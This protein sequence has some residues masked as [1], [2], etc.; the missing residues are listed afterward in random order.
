MQLLVGYD[1][2][3]GGGD[4]LELTRVIAEA[5][6][7]NVMV[8]T[9]LPYGPLPIPYEILEEEEA[10]RAQPLF[11]E[12]RERLGELEVETRAFGGG[13]PAGVINDLAE[14]EKV[15]TIVVGSPHRGPVGRTLIGSVADGLLH[16]APCEVMTAPRG[17]AEEEHGPFRTI[18]VAYDDTEEAKAALA[19]AEALALA[20]RATIVVY[21]VAAPPA[22][23]PGATG[24]TPA[25]AP[26]AGPIVTRAVKGVDE[27]LAATGRAL[28]GTPGA[29]IAAACEEIGAD[30]L[31]AGSRGYGPVMRVLL[32][33][34]STQLVHKAPCPVL[35][36]PR[37]DR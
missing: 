37:P 9:V 35:V 7:A 1:G 20:C 22:V 28:A 25:I 29:T 14:R 31:V 11:D 23:V 30:L 8:V 15:D 10:E 12:A 3:D 17:L 6:G 4:A 27:R 24:Y 19:R 34:V 5:T 16:G 32:G 26:E 33:S 36:V 21:T 13:S 2:S 18:A